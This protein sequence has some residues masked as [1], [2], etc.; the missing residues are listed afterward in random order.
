MNDIRDEQL[1]EMKQQL[2]IDAVAGGPMHS[3]WD[4]IF[5]IREVLSGRPSI[6]TRSDLA[7]LY[8]D[9]FKPAD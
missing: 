8:Q 3:N 9:K 1:I 2:L 7:A 6:M 5:D 4:I